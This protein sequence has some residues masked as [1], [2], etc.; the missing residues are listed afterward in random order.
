MIE[1][2]IM[3]PLIFGAFLIFGAYMLDPEE[4]GVIRIFMLLLALLTYFISSWFGALA[5]IEFYTFNAMQEAIV[6]GV[7]ILGSMIVV[8]IF[9]F[10]IYAFYKAA[11]AA[12]QRKK[13]MM[14]Q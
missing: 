1:A 7:W 6:T 3:T 4:H 8:L 10:L 2:I 12:A 11:H 9:Y 14:L 5:I 13:E